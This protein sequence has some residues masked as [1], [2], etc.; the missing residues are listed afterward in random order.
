MRYFL[1]C[2]TDLLI[3]FLIL[4]FYDTKKTFIYA[5]ISMQILRRLEG[6][7]YV[8]Q[9]FQSAKKETLESYS[10]FSSSHIFKFWQNFPQFFVYLC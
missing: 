9:L 10:F 2:S 3:I 6:R 4:N 7:K 5:I 8:V 1:D